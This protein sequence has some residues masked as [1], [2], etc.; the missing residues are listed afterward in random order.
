M[1]ADHELIEAEVTEMT[2]MLSSL[3]ENG[4]SLDLVNLI[5][6]DIGELVIEA[7]S[8]FYDAIKSDNPDKLY[9]VLGEALV[10][11]FL[12]NDRD[13][14]GLAQSFV[15]KANQSL[16]DNTLEFRI[17]FSAPTIN[18]AFI[19]TIIS[20]INKRGIRR[21]YAGFAGVLNPSHNYIQY[22]RV[23]NLT[24]SYDQLA[25][26]IYRTKQH[27]QQSDPTNP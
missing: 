27:L 23:G 16:Q 3:I 19:S 14:I 2:Q 25:G 7:L 8:D 22:Y 12:N 26:H 13:T 1:N 20:L 15:T 6:S 4:N 11:A 21:K 18:G 10:D 24:L 9:R 17:P 5:Y